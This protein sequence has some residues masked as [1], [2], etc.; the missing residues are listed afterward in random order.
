MFAVI[1]KLPAI[2]VL[3]PSPGYVPVMV[4]EDLAV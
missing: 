1:E 3:F 2:P 4:A